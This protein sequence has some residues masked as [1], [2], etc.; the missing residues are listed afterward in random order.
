MF[1]CPFSTNSRL[2][3]TYSLYY[4]KLFLISSCTGNDFCLELVQNTSI[5]DTTHVAL[6]TLLFTIPRDKP[7]F[8]S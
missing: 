4:G 7:Y 8:I 5:M 1:P 3:H 6:F 2:P